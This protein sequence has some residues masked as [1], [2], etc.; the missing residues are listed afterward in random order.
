MDEYYK[1][2]SR[3]AVSAAALF[4]NRENKILI[5]KPSYKD[6]WALPGGVSDFYESPWKTCL[7]EI[8]EEINLDI[9][10]ERKLLSVFYAFSKEKDR[11]YIQF[12]FYGGK[13]DN[14]QMKS[15]KI[16]NNE[17]VD[18]KFIKPEEGVN[19]L[20]KETAERVLKSIK[21]I[22]DNRIAYWEWN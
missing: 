8:K 14:K 7:R 2:L 10:E 13:L 6:Y 4:F 20:S 1:N 16:D 21:A 11:E 17:I 19:F 12:L 3:K 5:L 22:K 9:S 15:I 18:F